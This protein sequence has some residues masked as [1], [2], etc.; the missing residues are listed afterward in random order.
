MKVSII[1]TK[2]KEP[3]ISYDNRRTAIEFVNRILET[4]CGF[5]LIAELNTL[6]SEACYGYD[7]QL[8]GTCLNNKYEIPDY[9]I[10]L[11]LYKYNLEMRTNYDA[12]N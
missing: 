2:S 1:S 11:I 5:S 7:D 4:I 8:N 12:K 10:N 3:L 9:F 6:Q